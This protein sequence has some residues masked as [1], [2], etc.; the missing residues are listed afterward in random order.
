M[1]LPRCNAE[2]RASKHTSAP[3][4]T[5]PARHTSV[6]MRPAAEPRGYPTCYT[7]NLRKGS[8]RWST[9]IAMFHSC[10]W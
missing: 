10:N 8:D 1:T 4:R 2:R 6:I 7:T 9:F 5:E 3:K